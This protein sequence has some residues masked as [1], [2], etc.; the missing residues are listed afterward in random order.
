MAAEN[1]TW[2]E[3]HISNELKF[4]LGIRVSPRTVQKYLASHRGPTPDPSQR[5]LTFVHTHA[6]AIVA[7]DFVLVVTADS[8]SLMYSSS[9]SGCTSTQ[10]ACAGAQGKRGL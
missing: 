10:D 4:K 5:K 2:G 8:A 6:Q 7:C 1:P 9:W 3:E